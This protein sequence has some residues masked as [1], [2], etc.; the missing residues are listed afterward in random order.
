MMQQARFLFSYKQIFAPNN[1]PF[2]KGK[3]PKGEG[4]NTIK[5]KKR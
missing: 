3:Y 1:L 4:F 2:P 5:N